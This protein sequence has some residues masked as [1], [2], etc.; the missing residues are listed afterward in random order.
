MLQHL[1][2]GVR[3]RVVIAGDGAREDIIDN[4]GRNGGDEPDGGGEQG[5]GDAGRDDREVGRM[6][7]RDADKRVHDAPDGAKQ[8]NERSGRAD[9]GEHDPLRAPFCV[10]HAPRSGTARLRPAP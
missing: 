6:R 2:R 8:P 1:R 7:L 3:Q 9:G 10:L 5:F 4:H